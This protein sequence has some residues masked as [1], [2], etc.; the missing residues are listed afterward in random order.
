VPVL[1]NLNPSS[2]AK[3]VPATTGIYLEVYDVDNVDAASVVVSVDR[4]GDGQYE[5]VYSGG[6]FQGGYTGSVDTADSTTF[7]LTIDQQSFEENTPVHVN[8]LADDALAN[9]MDETYWFKTLEYP[10]PIFPVS[11]RE[12]ERLVSTGTDIVIAFQL[13]DPLTVTVGGTL[14]YDDSLVPKFRNGWAG[15]YLDDVDGKRLVLTPPSSLTI[16]TNYLVEVTTAS[17][18][19]DY[20]FRVGSQQITTTGDV[21]RPK[22]TEATASELWIGYTRAG[23]LVLRKGS[24]PGAETTVIAS[25]DWDH[26]YDPTL[27]KY[28]LYWI[29]NGKV[30]YSVAD[31]TD[32]PE[33]LPEVSVV[34]DQ[35]TVVPAG[36]SGQEVFENRNEQIQPVAI[37]TVPPDPLDILIY[38]PTGEPEADQIVGF[39]LYKYFAGRFNEIAFVPATPGET[40]AS[41]I[42]TGPYAEGVEYA[43]RPVYEI[44]GQVY[45][46]PLSS[47]E[48]P[49]EFG[50]TV[51][52]VPGGSSVHYVFDYGTFPPLVFYPLDNV[53]VVPAGS[54]SHR[55]FEYLS[56]EIIEYD[57]SD[58]TD[59]VTVVPAGSSGQVLLIGSGFGIIGVG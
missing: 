35:V 10:S 42:D 46:G 14:A 26:G 28:V 31:P 58:L 33:V 1:Q 49:G 9:S 23:E 18:G 21:E 19:L 29:D 53:A 7:K 6:S 57:P 34:N 36:S 24:P 39:R 30:F 56:Y 25:N 15:T 44:G 20:T 45:E 38:L 37:R 12:D 17:Y 32:P 41:Y 2:M 50:D 55:V 13:E 16:N 54:S 11:P 3:R 47:P 43:A 59:T 48:S 4:Q 51:T 40:N 8:V 52:V 5:L 27:G 22:L